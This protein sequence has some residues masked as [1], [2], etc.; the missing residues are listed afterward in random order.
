MTRRRKTAQG[1]FIDCLEFAV[2][3]GA[4]I[5]GHA[6]FPSLKAAHSHDLFIPVRRRL[7]ERRRS[8]SAQ[9]RWRARQ[10]SNL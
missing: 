3:A 6:C 9:G 5:E 8:M 4:K 7:G 1:R 2:P 10:E